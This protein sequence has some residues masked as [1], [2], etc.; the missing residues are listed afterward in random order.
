MMITFEKTGVATYLMGIK[1]SHGYTFP[2]FVRKTEEFQEGVKNLNE[3]EF[4]RLKVEGVMDQFYQVR[5]TRKS[6]K[7]STKM[8]ILVEGKKVGEFQ[9][10]SWVKEEEKEDVVVF[11]KE[12]LE[13]V[14]LKYLPELKE[15]TKKEKDKI[16]KA[17]KEKEIIELKNSIHFM[18]AEIESLKEENNFPLAYKVNKKKN[19]KKIELLKKEMQEKLLILKKELEPKIT[20]SVVEEK[21]E[22]DNFFKKMKK[23]LKLA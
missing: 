21:K 4:G 13:E 5:I 14:F 23:L 22:N 8:N 15:K 3:Y 6:E 9:L 1:K 2:E 20:N 10:A 7:N 12:V 11:F 17:K 19:L 16:E 18:K